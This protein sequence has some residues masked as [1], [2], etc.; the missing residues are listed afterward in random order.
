MPMSEDEYFEMQESAEAGR[1]IAG[2]AKAIFDAHD[3]DTMGRLQRVLYKYT[4]AGIAV[5]FELHEGAPG[6]P[7]VYPGDARAYEIQEPWKWVRRIGASSIVEGSDA[8][9][10]LRWIDLARYC[11]DEKYEGGLPDLA[12]AA[13]KDFDEMCQAVNDEACA[14]WDEA[15]GG[16]PEE[17]P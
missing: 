6:E 14:L 4:D 11:D 7:F 12:A 15:N 1:V 8:E 9:V 3:A 13:V 16:G 17:R 5:S 10:P 2:C